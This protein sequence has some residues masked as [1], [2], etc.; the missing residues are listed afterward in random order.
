MFQFYFPV[1]ISIC[2]GTP[3]V[4][5]SLVFY[6]IKNPDKFEKWVAIICKF[7]RFCS[8]YAEHKYVKYSV[9]SKINGFI[10]DVKKD[11]PNL[12]VENVQLEWIEENTTAEQFLKQNQL[13]LRMHKSKSDNR[14]IVRA[15]VAFVSFALLRKAKKYIA[16]YQKKTIDLFATT[17]IL[18]NGHSEFL[19]D[20]VELYLADAMDNKKV[21]DLF[22]K[23]EDIH[24]VRMF[25]PVFINELNFLGEKV[26][27]KAKNN[28]AVF[29]EVSSLANFLYIYS[30]R[31][32]SEEVQSDYT[33]SFCKFS[34]RI[35]G[36]NWKIQNEGKK[37][38][39][40]NIVSTE[41]KVETL[42]LLGDLS[43]RS[44]INGVVRDVTTQ[45]PFYVFNTKSYKCT[46]KDSEGEDMDVNTYLVVL[47]NKNIQT[48]HK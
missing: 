43:N 4:I 40:K 13:V 38:Y 41:D 25:F 10:K 46:I 29:D 27:S 18:E 31:K 16:D 32:K 36:K 28:Q 3:L 30:H 33:G 15:T 35:V 48:F 17:K 21:N 26:F 7:F 37:V 12:N 22:A 44:F 19:A 23:F 39:V 1:T 20:F 47:R 2:I 34:I 14:N 11:V 6:F 45:I 42:Y 9:Q 5:G 8:D 24:K